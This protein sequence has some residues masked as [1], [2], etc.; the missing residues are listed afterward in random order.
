MSRVA[1]ALVLALLLRSAVAADGIREYIDEVTAASITAS[2]A[3]LIFAQ[4]RTDLA[5]NARDY[6]TLVPVEINQSGARRGFWSGYI[7]STLDRRDQPPVVAAGDEIVLLADNRPIPLHGDGKT[8]R[9]HGVGTPITRAPVRGSVPVIFPATQEEIAY[10]ARAR[11]VHIELIRAG[12]SER[13]TL[14]KG[15]PAR[16]KPFAARIEP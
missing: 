6:I 14:W 10:V 9:D 13:F 16:L 12:I 4:E 8:P 7:W 3:P 15:K 5:V 11:E 1:L 2:A